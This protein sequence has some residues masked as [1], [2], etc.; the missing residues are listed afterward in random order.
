MGVERMDVLGDVGKVVHRRG[1]GSVLRQVDRDGSLGMP[2]GTSVG[3][4]RVACT[5]LTAAPRCAAQVAVD[6]SSPLAKSRNVS[7]AG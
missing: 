5:P 2:D 7:A 4:W 6:C 1:A 3:L